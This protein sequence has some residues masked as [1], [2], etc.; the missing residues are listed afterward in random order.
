MLVTVGAIRSA[1]PH[2]VLNNPATWPDSI[3]ED[4]I[5]AA[6]GELEVITGQVW[7]PSTRTALV[8]VLGNGDC[9]PAKPLRTVT[10]IDG[11]AVNIPGSLI[12]KIDGIVRLP[13]SA[14]KVI[15]LTFTCGHDLPT[16][17]DPKLRALRSAFIHRVVMLLQQARS[18]IDP[19]ADRFTG[20]TG[21]FVWAT[22]PSTEST[23]VPE[24]NAV[25]NA[26]RRRANFA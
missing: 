9:R 14:G 16:S 1:D 17:T 20:S 25:Y 23:G 19:K 12:N 26:H 21:T 24:I 13:S 5:Y 18:G 8:R 15:E 10:H 3:I 11:E 2:E 6:E 22:L 7:Q 4:C